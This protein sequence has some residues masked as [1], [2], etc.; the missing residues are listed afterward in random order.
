MQDRII[1]VHK[2][3]HPEPPTED[4]IREIFQEEGLTPH[5]WQND[6]GHIYQAHKHDYHKI[7]FVVSGSIVFGFPVDNEPTTLIPGH[8]L[9]LPAGVIHNAVVGDE[10]VVCLEAHRK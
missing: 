9:D 2:W 5:R 4:R 6:P 1:S 3:E 7:V 8:R 10:G